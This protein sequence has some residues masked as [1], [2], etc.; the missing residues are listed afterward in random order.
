[1]RITTLAGAA[2]AGTAVLAL[3]ACGGSGTSRV[4][5][6]GGGDNVALTVTTTIG[7]PDN[8][9]NVPIDAF[10]SAVEEASDGRVSF[11]FSYANAIVPPA[12]VGGAMADGTVDGGLV[13]TSYNPSEFPISNWASKLA[14]AGESG[15]PV[16]AL[17]RAAAVTE[18]WHTH[19]DA[20]QA[21]FKD[22]GLMPLTPG[23]N[24]HTTYHLI[25]TDPITSLAD[26]QGKSVRSPGEAWAETASAI[27]MEPVSLPGAEMY[28]SLQRGIVDCVMADATD[29]VS[30]DLTEVAKHYTTVNLPGFTAYG[31]FLSQQTWDSLDPELQTIIW[32][33]IP[34][35]L[36]SLTQEGLKLQEELLETSGMEF[37]TMDDDLAEAL[38]DHQQSVLDEAAEKAPD[39]L[40]DPQAAVDQFVDL[41]DKWGSIVTDELAVENY[42]SWAEWH[43]AGGT[44]D[45][46]DAAAFAQRVY[47]EVY[48]DSAPQ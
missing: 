20:M 30:S 44:A 9:H 34:V 7:G 41:H 15:P 25:C 23:Y 22:Q 47:D 48:A 3:T 2:I 13:V 24:A 1:M 10:F 46:I 19:P 28:E 27:G 18:W 17:D 26:A 37:H 14:F 8:Y 21:D 40:A 29:M 11:D 5:D 42:D 6:D 31:I 38:A 43:E 35:Y 12:E 36:E 4:A 45:D 16:S 32:E 33:Q 39:T